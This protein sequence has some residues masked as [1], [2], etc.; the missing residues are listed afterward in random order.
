MTVIWGFLKALPTK[1]WG[2]LAMAGG[3]FLALAYFYFSTKNKGKTE[4]ETKAKIEDLTEKVVAHEKITHEIV[5]DIRV[6]NEIESEINALPP[7]DVA[8]RAGKWVRDR[9]RD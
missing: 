9:A 4:A 8:V 3:L 5:E 1:L 7:S 2:Y 6:V